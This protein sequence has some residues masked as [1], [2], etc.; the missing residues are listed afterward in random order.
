MDDREWTIEDIIDE[1]GS[2]KAFFM[3]ENE[4]CYP[5]VLDKATDALDDYL[6]LRESVIE[7]LKEREAQKQ[8]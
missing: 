3:D 5:L 7:L 1:L 2:I 8:K 4:G 6:S